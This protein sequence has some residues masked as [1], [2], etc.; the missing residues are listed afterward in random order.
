[1]P[2]NGELAPDFD[3]PTATGKSLKLSSL[4]GHP[5]VLYF[6]PEADTPGCTVESKGFRDIYA[7][8]QRKHVAV[9]GVSCD[10]VD[11]QCAF[12]EKY[13]LPFPLVAD[14]SKAVATAYGV[15]RPSGRARR[16]TFFLGADG[17]IQEIVDVSEAS[18]H[19]ARAQDLYLK[20]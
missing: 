3:A 1:M 6:Y 19:V 15:L 20:S 13:S 10:P 14:A 16:V 7:D 17:K 18:R 8:L 12:A 9:V 11:K 4:R 5:V 2:A